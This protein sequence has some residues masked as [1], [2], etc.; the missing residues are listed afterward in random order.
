MLDHYNGITC[1][2]QFMQHVQQLLNIV[3]MQ[4]LVVGSSR[5]YRVLPVS[6]L[7]SSRASF[8]PLRFTTRQSGGGL[9][10]ADISA[11]TNVHQG[12]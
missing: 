4:A 11:Q 12:F 6:R 5:I 2:T 9:T 8:H 10:E 3:K 7:L 1:I